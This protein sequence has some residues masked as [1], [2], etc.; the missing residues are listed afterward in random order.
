[1]YD[2]AGSFD[3]MGDPILIFMYIDDFFFRMGGEI[4]IQ[5]LWLVKITRRRNVG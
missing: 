2:G 4:F 5:F 1:M 3:R